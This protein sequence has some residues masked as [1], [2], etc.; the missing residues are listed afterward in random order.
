MFQD[1]F[2]L[3]NPSDEDI[4]SAE[5][6]LGI[7]IPE[8]YLWF[9][10]KYG[11]GGFFFELLGNSLTGNFLFVSETLKQRENGLPENLMVICCM[12]QYKQW[13]YSVMEPLR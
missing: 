9:L 8:S 6:A 12:Y 2:L 7:E 5:Q 13:K 1:A 3:T 11:H 4:K 10:K